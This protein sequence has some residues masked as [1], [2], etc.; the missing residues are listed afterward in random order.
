MSPVQ[1]KMI[2]GHCVSFAESMLD[3]YGKLPPFGACI[4]AE[5]E[6]STYL[7]LGDELNPDAIMHVNVAEVTENFMRE[8]MSG[9][10][11]I[12]ATA[13][14]VNIIKS[15]RAYFDGSMR[16]M[17]ETMDSHQLIFVPYNMKRRGI[18]AYKT[19]IKF[20]EPIIFRQDPPELQHPTLH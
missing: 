5:G 9:G 7:L 18:F 17:L 3:A 6:V 19:K 16:L 15:F 20:A 13:V 11:A 2:C 8:K 4:S 1:I 12:V 14:D 10:S